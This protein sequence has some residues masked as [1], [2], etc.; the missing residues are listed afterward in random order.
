LRLVPD[1]V[2]SLIRL[3]PSVMVIFFF[4]PFS[5]IFFLSLLGTPHFVR[6]YLGFYCITVGA[7]PLP[8]S[9]KKFNGLFCN[10][11][12][13]LGHAPSNSKKKRAVFSCLG[14]PK[15]GPNLGLD[16]PSVSI[17]R[18]RFW[19]ACTRPFSTCPARA[20][21]ATETKPPPRH[22][23]HLA[24]PGRQPGVGSW[25]TEQPHR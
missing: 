6:F 8:T 5:F 4:Y 18:V 24:A 23:W 7:S 3:L 11:K 1:L 9:L 25:N 20:I 19:W 10:A 17:V 21:G 2:T 22:I 14:A 15:H 12:V 16:G 13:G